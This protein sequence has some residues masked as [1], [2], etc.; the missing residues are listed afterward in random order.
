MIELVQKMRGRGDKLLQVDTQITT[1]LAHAYYSCANMVE[2][3][4]TELRKLDK[5][6]KRRLH[7]LENPDI[8]GVP[9]FYSPCC[10]WVN[11]S[12]KKEG[13]HG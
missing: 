2:A 13:V 3:S 8:T 6:H 12:V 7:M 4:L 9:S 1:D 10:Q 5:H 11:K